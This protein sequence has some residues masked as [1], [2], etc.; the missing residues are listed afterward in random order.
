M[1]SIRFLALLGSL[2]LA[3]PAHAGI[4]WEPGYKAP[5]TPRIA[6]HQIQVLFWNVRY[7]DLH[8]PRQSNGASQLEYNLL[9]LYQSVWRPDITVFSECRAGMFS[10]TFRNA[11]KQ[12]YPFTKMVRYNETTKSEGICVFSRIPFLQSAVVEKID[13]RPALN[14][15]E[16]QAYEN[17][18]S[19]IPD[20]SG[21]KR[22]PWGYFPSFGRKFTSVLFQSPAGPIQIFPVHLMNPWSKYS[23]EAG[24]LGFLRSIQAIHAG[25][26]APIYFQLENLLALT[27]VHRAPRM[28]ALLIGDFNIPSPWG[29]GYRAI[30][31]QGWFDTF[32]EL[33]RKATF[34]SPSSGEKTASLFGWK[35][36]IP[37]KIDHSFASKGT[38]AQSVVL[39]LSGSDHFPIWTAVVP[40]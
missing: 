5:E 38:R 18:W 36:R 27:K 7:N 26:N 10:E 16:V 22:V 32:P 4:D 23:L 6:Q 14:P 33:E 30:I 31:D 13:W 40:Y 39:P 15:A 20:A 8:H 1:K 11:W 21:G 2:V 34:P 28:P 25:S 9:G 3:L 37:L 12:L 29:K 24:R 19:T 17:F 35:A